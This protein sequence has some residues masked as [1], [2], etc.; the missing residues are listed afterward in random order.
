MHINFHQSIMQDMSMS[1]PEQAEL[2][3]INTIID[4]SEASP[5]SLNLRCI[6]LGG[7]FGTGVDKQFVP[8]HLSHLMLY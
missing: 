6:A 2:D 3:G 8:D 7:I 5:H 1:F 4:G